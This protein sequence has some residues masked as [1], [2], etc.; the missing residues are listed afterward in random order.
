MAT[1]FYCATDCDLFKRNDFR[2]SKSMMGSRLGSALIQPHDLL[3][4]SEGVSPVTSERG[5]T[6][7]LGRSIRQS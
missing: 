1:H 4:Q 3:E 6:P 7:T 5:E 2:S